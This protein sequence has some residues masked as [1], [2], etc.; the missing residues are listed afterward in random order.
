MSHHMTPH[1]HHM[2]PYPHPPPFMPPGGYPY[3]EP[4]MP[5][6][7]MHP[8]HS[9]SSDSE[10]RKV[11]KDNLPSHSEKKSLVDSKLG[12]DSLVVDKQVSKK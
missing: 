9:H 1:H 6:L 4:M 2:Y 3:R 11:K 7:P 12:S 10:S 8:H 5:P